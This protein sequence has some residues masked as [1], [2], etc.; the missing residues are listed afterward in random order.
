MVSHKISSES[1]VGQVKS[2][3]IIGALDSNEIRN[4]FLN[5]NLNSEEKVLLYET[6][7]LFHS[8]ELNLN[9]II[10]LGDN[11]NDCGGLAKFIN[12]NNLKE[13]PAYQGIFKTK[14]YLDNLPFLQAYIEVR[15]L[16]AHCIA[17]K[18][19]ETNSFVF[20][21]ANRLDWNTKI[22]NA[23]KKYRG[24][25]IPEDIIENTSFYELPPNHLGFNVVY[26]PLLED[27]RSSLIPIVEYIATFA[28]KESQ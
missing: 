26:L 4:L 13:N 8:I 28:Q 17:A 14:F 23:I 20:V 12:D 6:L 10:G 22:N 9:R 25:G 5:G 27:I 18:H 11:I 2:L 1:A 7:S 21:S 15:H 3:K 16:I 19:H 24:L